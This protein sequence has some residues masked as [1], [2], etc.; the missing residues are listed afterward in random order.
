MRFTSETVSDG[1]C[2]QLFVLDGITGVLWQLAGPPAPARWCCS[3][4]AGAAATPVFSRGWL[5]V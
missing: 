1:V 5:G 3:A 2:E 4:M